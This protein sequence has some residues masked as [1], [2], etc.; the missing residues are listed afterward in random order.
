MTAKTRPMAN[1][2]P[3]GACGRTGVAFRNGTIWEPEFCACPEC[4]GTGCEP[5]KEAKD[6]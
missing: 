5:E 3:C 4:K 6:A 1:D 2:K